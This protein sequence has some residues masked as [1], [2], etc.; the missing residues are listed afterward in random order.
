M[1]KQD[2]DVMPIMDL[3]AMPWFQTRL[4]L[5]FEQGWPLVLNKAG[6]CF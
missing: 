3:Q 2:A 6:L 4:A 5:G 1:C